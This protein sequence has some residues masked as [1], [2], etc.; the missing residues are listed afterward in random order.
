[1]I[2]RVRLSHSLSR[3]VFG[4][5]PPLVE[6]T[7]TEPVY[8]IAK[9]V[10]RSMNIPNRSSGRAEFGAV[11][12]GSLQIMSTPSFIF[13]TPSIIALWDR[14]HSSTS[15]WAVAAFS[16]S[17]GRAAWASRTGRITIASIVRSF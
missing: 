9:T 17:S 5:R 12:A 7:P 15:A 16:R 4:G 3:A 10:L 14:I 2:N 13:K 11:P 6:P 1:L 8:F